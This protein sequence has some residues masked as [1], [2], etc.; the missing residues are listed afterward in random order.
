MIVQND[1]AQAF[2]TSVQYRPGVGNPIAF[3]PG[4]GRVKGM[5]MGSG[6]PGLSREFRID[7][8]FF[9]YPGG[10]VNTPLKARADDRFT[11]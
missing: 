8:V 7:G 11:D 9:A 1:G 3:G 5:L 10:A 2:F 4:I 6:N